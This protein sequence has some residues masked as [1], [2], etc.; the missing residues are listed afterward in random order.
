MRIFFPINHFGAKHLLSFKCTQKSVDFSLTHF[1]KME[2]FTILPDY[3]PNLMIFDWP[4]DFL[5]I[6]NN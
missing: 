6:V 5:I 1:F 2:L 4:N 3:K